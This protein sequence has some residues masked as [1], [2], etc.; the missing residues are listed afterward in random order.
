MHCFTSQN[1]PFLV[2]LHQCATPSIVL[3][4]FHSKFL[5]TADLLL[6]ITVPSLALT[7]TVGPSRASSTRTLGVITIAPAGGLDESGLV[8]DPSQ[9]GFQ[10]G[11]PLALPTGDKDVRDTDPK[12]DID[13]EA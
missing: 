3:L 4:L 1:I 2:L 7:P 6:S 13:W 8:T 11:R 9:V 12:T 10:A 5:F